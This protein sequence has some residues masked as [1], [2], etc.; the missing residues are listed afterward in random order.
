MVFW[1]SA[2]CVT[3][4]AEVGTAP[5][6]GISLN[7]TQRPLH[8]QQHRQQA[9]GQLFKAIRNHLSTKWPPFHYFVFWLEVGSGIHSLIS[10][11]FIQIQ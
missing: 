11:L 9:K 8:Q 10:H 4:R 5:P 3:G 7:V 2:R 1:Q 6:T